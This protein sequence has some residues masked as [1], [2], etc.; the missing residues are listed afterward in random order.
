MTRRK[1]LMLVLAVG[2]LVVVIPPASAQRFQ[3][4]Q[5]YGPTQIAAGSVSVW[6]F[7]NS[8]PYQVFRYDPRSGQ[9]LQ[10]PTALRPYDLSVGGG[11]AMQNDEVWAV[12]NF[13]IYRWSESGQFFYQIPGGNFYFYDV[14][15]G[16]GYSSCHPYEVWA[17]TITGAVRYNYCTSSF[18]SI[19]EGNFL[20]SVSTGGGEVWA[21]GV[22]GGGGGAY[23]VLRFNPATNQFDVMPGFLTRI[24]VG[25]A[26]VWG[27]YLPDSGYP[28]IYQFNPATQNWDQIPGSLTDI[29]S[30]GDGIFGTYDIHGVEVKAYRLD[31]STRAWQLVYNSTPLCDVFV[32]AG[33]GGGVWM[34][35]G[36]SSGS[37]G[38]S[39]YAYLTF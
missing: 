34:D 5:S 37:Q 15:V 18:E 23:Q 11:N 20:Y 2:F 1:S 35:A 26:G 16:A 3:F 32:A 4:V 19:S 14:V 13:N 33:S 36:C 31:P 24:S 39:D 12:D 21:L 38:N 8:Y 9:F 25:A 27:V 28:S 10:I 22:G 7:N 29:S 6:G 30:G 17:T